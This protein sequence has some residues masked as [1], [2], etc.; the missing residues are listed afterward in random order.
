MGV[1]P[2]LGRAFR[3]D[4]DQVPGRDAVVMLGHDFWQREFGADRSII[5][6]TVRL[7]GIDFTVIGVTPAGF[8]GLDQY[9]RYDVLRAAHDVAA[10]HRRSQRPALRSARFPEPQHQRDASNPA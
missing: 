8:T 6:R 2:E 4:E 1:E 10:P 7:N 3:P 5:G 9:I